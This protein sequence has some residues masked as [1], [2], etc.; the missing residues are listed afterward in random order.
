MK[1]IVVG[2]P[3]DGDRPL[4]R[5]KELEPG[6]IFDLKD[7]SWRQGEYGLLYD[8]LDADRGPL[9]LPCTPTLTKDLGRVKPGWPTAVRFNGKQVN[10]KTGREF[11]SWTVTVDSEEALLPPG[12]AIEPAVREER[13]ATAKVPNW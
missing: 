3:A 4:I 12:T 2:R 1:K 7:G 8:A 5:L 13:P 9:T 11:Y 10:P 6:T